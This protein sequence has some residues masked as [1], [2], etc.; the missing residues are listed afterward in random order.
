[1][2][3]QLADDLDVLALLTQY[4]HDSVNV[5]SLADEGGKHH[6]HP[7]LYTELQVLD[8]LLR[9]SGQVYFSTRQVHTF[10]AAQ[11]STILDLTHQVVTTWI[12]KHRK[13]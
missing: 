1:M 8:I 12:K 9:Y 11:H 4:L 2:V 5:S 7:L 6:V 13:L 10:L 3:L